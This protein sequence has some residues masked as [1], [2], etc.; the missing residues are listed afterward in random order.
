MFWDGA[1]GNAVTGRIYDKGY[2]NQNIDL[3]LL[4]SQ[5]LSSHSYSKSTF[6]RLG[7]VCDWTISYRFQPIS[8]LSSTEPIKI[9]IPFSEKMK[10]NVLYTTG[11]TGTATFPFK[12]FVSSGGEEALA[13]FSTPTEA[14]SYGG[15]HLIISPPTTGWDPSLIFLYVKLRYE[16]S[17]ILN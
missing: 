6:F 10:L 14:E 7:R 8:T 15:E 11:L 9:K 2:D 16:V 17:D 3:K 4:C 1:A 13:R 5:I 12:A